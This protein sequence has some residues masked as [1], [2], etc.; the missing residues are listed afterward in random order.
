M[1]EV[2]RMPKKG[3][4][5]ERDEALG[6]DPGGFGGDQDYD[7]IK[8]LGEGRSSAAP[9][10]PAT[11]APAVALRTQ[12]RPVTVPSRPVVPYRPDER[13]PDPLSGSDT[14]PRVGTG[15]ERSGRRHRSGPVT[16][17]DPYADVYAS[18][19]RGQSGRLAS[20]DAGPAAA[21]PDW[22]DSRIPSTEAGRSR[23]LGRRDRADGTGRGTSTDINSMPSR[24]EGT[25]PIRQAG[26]RG[27]ADRDSGS[28]QRGASANG[29]PS[30]DEGRPVT[31]PGRAV[32]VRPGNATDLLFNPAA[33]AY[34]QP[35]YS[36]S[37]NS[38]QSPRGRQP[39]APF[40]SPQGRLDTAEYA[41]PLY[42]SFESAPS[43]PAWPDDDPFADNDARGGRPGAPARGGRGDRT[44][45][46]RRVSGSSDL[47]ALTGPQRVS[48]TGPQ[49][50]VTG[51][52]DID[53]LTGPQRR[54]D[55]LSRPDPLT[56]SGIGVLWSSEPAA[57]QT[58]VAPVRRASTGP[59]DRLAIDGPAPLAEPLDQPAPALPR[60]P[61]RTTRKGSRKAGK[62][63]AAPKPG[64]S[65]TRSGKRRGIA[66]LLVGVL[67]VIVGA[68]AYGYLKLTSG[69]S[70]RVT[71]PAAIG[72]F[73]RQQADATATNLK[74][75]ILSA[76]AGSV[77]N[78]VAAVYEQKK[79]PGTS[80]G[81]QVVVFIGGN[82]T[83][84]GSASDLIGAYMA[85]LHKSFTTS[86]GSL[87]GQAACAPGSNGGPSEC[88]WADGDTFGVL[89]S[90]TM[91]AAS[92]ADEMRQMRP[93]VEHAVN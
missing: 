71:T 51:S 38:G 68:G 74:Q 91:S 32:K 85:R 49:R 57:S 27:L 47:A 24:G 90:A 88:T 33:E 61:A 26:R 31:R 75:K 7:W 18:P 29:Q 60:E 83:G 3:R 81:P 55:G 62:K 20:R 53:Q 82:L 39:D 37:E 25:G 9:S 23:R 30:R 15:V 48:R 79:G 40:S 67:V 28:D 66:T 92:L 46:Q 50:R 16:G 65:R 5:T 42:S 54:T 36:P 6:S 59:L 70:H 73:S 72:A 44:G 93:L 89:V 78:V 86:P 11:A 58:A 84:N 10:S 41:K 76:G 64:K 2:S 34:D 13:D 21:G 56:D 52:G 87:G 19:D 45:P 35:L 22:T 43:R 1:L 17:T 69:I 77:K 4:R 80:K 63:A 14:D 12:A 8:Y